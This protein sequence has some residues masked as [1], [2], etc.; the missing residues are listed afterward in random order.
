M[1]EGVINVRLQVD[2]CR[3]VRVK[4]TTSKVSELY[5]CILL[6]NTFILN[7]EVSQGYQPNT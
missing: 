7:K 5:V 4:S 1:L 3:A 2:P 6:P